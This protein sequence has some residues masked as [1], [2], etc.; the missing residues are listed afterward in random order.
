M[1]QPVL[2]LLQQPMGVHLM[3]INGTL[4]FK[5]KKLNCPTGQHCCC[6]HVPAD[7]LM[8]PV[9]VLLP[10]QL[11]ADAEVLRFAVA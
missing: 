1:F 7:V 3:S 2:A 9:A 10:V 6:A 5:P 8:F 11:P 4:L